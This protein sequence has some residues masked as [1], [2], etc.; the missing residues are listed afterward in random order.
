MCPNRAIVLFLLF[1]IPALF[2]GCGTEEPPAGQEEAAAERRAAI[3]RLENP[4]EVAALGKVIPA[5]ELLELAFETSGR[6]EHIFS[7]EGQ[8]VPAG[9]P[10]IALDTRLE[11]NQWKTLEAQLERNWL[12][13][14][15]ARAQQQYHEE[16]LENHRQTYQR[17]K[18]SV[19]AGALPASELDPVELDM[20]SSRNQADNAG[21]LL[22]RLQAQARELR[23]Q[24]EEVGL[25]RQQKEL[26]APGE[27]AV[28]RWEVREGATVSAY[29]R[30]GEFAP[31]GPLLLEA[32][33]DEY[34]AT[35][36]EVG[37]RAVIRREG[38][39]DTLARGQV[40]FTAD[41]LSEKSVLSEDNSQFEDLQVRRIKIR[42]EGESGLLLGMKVEALIQTGENR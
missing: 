31:A 14:E 24:Q 32:E 18:R 7:Q 30:V 40:I 6:V 3:R 28:L 39:T 5:E 10:L 11:D 33:V 22:Q 19:D 34:F 27:G 15:D 9:S 36:V 35:N 20:K 1:T 8:S 16:I 37:Q 42:L 25:R 29:Q 4:E 23:L 2:F 21:R 41:K 26:K 17:L 38:Y 13:Q 12:E